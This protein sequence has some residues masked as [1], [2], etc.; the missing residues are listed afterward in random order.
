[1]IFQ[2]IDHGFPSRAIRNEV[3][4]KQEKIGRTRSSENEILATG[5]A[6]LLSACVL[7]LSYY[8][9]RYDR[10]EY[11]ILENGKIAR[12]YSN[13]AVLT[14]VLGHSVLYSVNSMLA[15]G[16][17]VYSLGSKNPWWSL[18]AI[19]LCLVDL[20]Y[21]VSAAIIAIWLFFSHL[22]LLTALL[23]TVGIILL[24]IGEI[25]IWMGVLHLYE[26]RTFK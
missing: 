16:M 23:F 7:L 2:V 9:V 6:L 25:W 12:G 21:D 14:L 20:V 8:S 22:P 1:M 4:V 11:S 26:Q 24:I 10:A 15:I 13:K 17:L 3:T 5:Q 19:V 18:P